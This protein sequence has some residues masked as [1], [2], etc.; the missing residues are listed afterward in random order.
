MKN[1]FLFYSLLIS[2]LLLWSCEEEDPTP[3][4]NQTPFSD[5]VFISCE[6]GFGQGN[7][8]VYFLNPPRMEFTPGIYNIVNQQPVGDVLQSMEFENEKAYLVVNNSGKIL[9]VDDETFLQSGIIEG[10]SAPTEMDVVDDKGYI[11]SLYS[12]HIVVADMNSLELTDS[13]YLGVQSNLVRESDNRLWVLSQSEYQSRTKDHIYYINLATS[14]VDSI[15]VS[16]NPISWAY[17][18]KDHLYVFCQGDETNGEPAMYSISTINPAVTQKIDLDAPSGLFSQ[19][20]Y[21]EFGKRI[22][23]QLEDG[24]YSFQPGNAEV[25]ETPLIEGSDHAFLYG[26]G[27]SPEN[28]DIYLGDA[29]DFSSAGMVYIYSSDGQPKASLSV[30]IGPNNFYFE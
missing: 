14:I 22:L 7:A 16:A 24:I 21:D 25:S 3:P 13:L 1:V 9:Q 23:I 10:L 29:K 2:A 28:G 11:G 12:E 5:G 15:E 30:G 8:S 19:I 4:D 26:L 17:D 6:G 20:A 27:I 18:D